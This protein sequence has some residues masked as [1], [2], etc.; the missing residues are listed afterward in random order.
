GGTTRVTV[1]ASPQSM[2]V[3]PVNLAGGVTVHVAFRASSGPVIA[4]PRARRASIINSESRARSGFRT[5]TVASPRAASVRTRL[6]RDFDAGTDT[7]AWTGPAA[8]GAGHSAGPGAGAC[9]VMGPEPTAGPGV[10][11]CF[12][13][14]PVAQVTSS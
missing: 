9:S 13:G 6:V 5:C 14:Q 11:S 10:C 3:S 7:C 4:T 1:P 2:V 12:G 8:Y